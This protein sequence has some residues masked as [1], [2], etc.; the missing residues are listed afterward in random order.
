MDA[1]CPTPTATATTTRRH[2]AREVGIRQ[3]HAGSGWC[4]ARHARYQY[5]TRRHGKQGGSRRT[6]AHAAATAGY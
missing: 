4:K 6:A 2:D 5:G 3:G 1:A